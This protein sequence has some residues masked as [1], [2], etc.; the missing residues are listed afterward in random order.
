MPAIQ[1][2]IL[3][4]LYQTLLTCGPFA[5]DDV[6]RAV[7][8]DTR[9]NAWYHQLP[10]A[11][12]P[13]ERVKLVV[14]FLR[15][16]NSATQENALILLLHV[17]SE[18]TASNDACHQTL[19]QLADELA[20]VLVSAYVLA[21][22]SSESRPY[23]NVPW[24]D[25][26]CFVGREKALDWVRQRLSS[27]D[28]TCRIAVTG[29]GGVGKSA[30]AL[31][32]AHEYIERYAELP[33]AERF[34]AIIWIS[35]KEEVLTAQG[36]EPA[37]LPYMILHTLE[38]VYTAIA[39]TLEREDITR[40]LPEDQ[41]PLVESALKRQRTLL[42]LDNLESV[43][44]DRV[45]P[46]LR[47]LRPPTK[48]II[49]SR[50]WVE[51]ADILRLTGLYWE[52][53]GQLIN[54]EAQVHGVTL[55]EIQRKRIFDLTSGLPLPIKLS[56]ARMAGGESF[57][58][59]T[60]WLSDAT[61]DLPEYCIKGQIELVRQRNPYAWT[62]LLACS[63][64]DREAGA[65]GEALGY[66]A[67]VSIVDRDRAL[68]ELQRL[69]LVNRNER[70]RFWV[71]P[72]VQRYAKMQFAASEDVAGIVE[73]WVEWAV[74]FAKDY[75]VDWD[76]T[77]E[78]SVLGIE[79]P[80]LLSCVRW[81]RERRQ[82]TPLFRL[83]ATI[84]FYAYRS[85]LLTEFREILESAKD[86][87][88]ALGDEQREGRVELE[89][90]RLFLLYDQ[91]DQAMEYYCKAEEI[92]QRYGNDLEL[93]R[94]WFYQSYLL[95]SKGKLTEA[96]KLAQQVLDKGKQL[97]NP[98]LQ[99]LALEQLADLETE[100]GNVDKAAE[101]LCQ[102]ESIA[103]NSNLPR[104]VCVFLYRRARNSITKG[105]YLAAEFLLEQALKSLTGWK[106]T[107]M[108]GHV[109]YRLAIVYEKTDRMQLARQTAQE[110]WD[111]YERLG[112]LG[113]LNEMKP[114]LDRLLSSNAFQETTG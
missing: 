112:I 82:W 56:V 109:K 87:A 37:A 53:A 5:N 35:A 7:F 50:E 61:G 107:H 71:L 51:V 65:S 32:I 57:D 73:R 26:A 6:L 24:P 70:D 76:W 34:E 95:L 3:N 19:A 48:A 92:A 79:Y 108:I 114:L 64:F 38:D 30:L 45:K 25:Y 21:S 33:P 96:E 14:D 43:K 89:L 81:L 27:K 86:A 85:S 67:S 102:G 47:C 113:R 41:G 15:Q 75:V 106:E 111:I 49:T 40:A 46:F 58:A 16:R 63:L 12:N 18:Q 23:H 28:H 52:E 91:P 44:D 29:I 69:F 77:P 17:L 60:R 4:R 100:K 104:R 20:P 13:D 93:G 62:I 2:E 31:A 105:D 88:K 22:G 90:G 55:D 54:E 9:L 59:V 68:G 103:R 78:W 8:A 99:T 39:R 36:T 72:I 84:W 10:Q 101:W 98:Y 66:V 97:D 110:A 42:I 1:A 80:N 94:A 74:S 11:G 83:A